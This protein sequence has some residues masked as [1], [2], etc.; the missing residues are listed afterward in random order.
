MD[1]ADRTSKPR[2]TW[3]RIFLAGVVA[4][5]ILGWLARTWLPRQ[6]TGRVPTR[7][8]TPI[9]VQTYLKGVAYPTG[10][11]RLLER[12]QAAGADAPVL[13]TLTQL[14]E[15]RYTSPIEV[16]RALG[17]RPERGAER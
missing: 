7:A 1:V 10:K 11:H 17:T 6:K 14:P 5:G 12:A 8:V 2:G 13:E 4:G 16:S 3:E 15:Q 9:Q